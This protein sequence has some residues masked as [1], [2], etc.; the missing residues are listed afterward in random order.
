MLQ[1]SIITFN[2]LS[3]IHTI[4]PHVYFYKAEVFSSKLSFKYEKKNEKKK[5]E[6]QAAHR[7]GTD[8]KKRK[9]NCGMCRMGNAFSSMNMKMFINSLGDFFSC[10]VVFMKQA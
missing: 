6:Q 10:S 5:I 8:I 7:N 9:K 1:A 2:D 4:I 3:N